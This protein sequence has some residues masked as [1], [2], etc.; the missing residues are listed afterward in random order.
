MSVG[1]ARFGRHG[2]KLFPL[3]TALAPFGALA[4]ASQLFQTNEALGIGVQDVL[5]DG[6]IRAQLKPSLSLLHGDASPGGRPSAFALEPLLETRVM[7]SFRSHLLSRVKL[8]VVVWGSHGSEI[9][10]SQVNPGS[11]TDLRVWGQEL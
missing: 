6:V 4:N 5:G 3:A 9:A 2:D 8:R 7:I 11:E 10:L 1:S